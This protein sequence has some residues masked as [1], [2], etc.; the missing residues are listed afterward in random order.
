[1][2]ARHCAAIALT[3]SV[4]LAACAS[5]DFMPTTFL[6]DRCQ[7]EG[8]D[9][10]R[11]VDWSNVRVVPIIIRQDRFEPMVIRVSQNEPYIFRFTNRDDSDHVFRAP[12]FFE[13]IAVDKVV[14]AGREI[15][16][17]CMAGIGVP[18]GAVIDMHFI[19]S[20]DGRYEFTDSRFGLP[21]I[22]AAGTSGVIYIT[23]PRERVESPVNLRVVEPPPPVPLE[24][25]PETQ[26]SPFG[27][28]SGFPVDPSMQAPGLDPGMT[29]GQLPGDT[30]IRLPG[31]APIALPGDAPMTLPGDAP[32]A[33]PGDA[34]LRLPGDTPVPAA[35]PSAPS[36]GTA[37]EGLAQ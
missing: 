30:P 36:A 29:S 31:D 8:Q 33:L 14:V 6:E 4:G 13:S 16:E 1:M 34:P 28:P 3:L 11:T 27:L 24:P 12:D 21:A 37:T 18:P 15:Q 25:R 7:A 22:F 9:R 32:V 23:V 26:P 10:L 35:R 19:P 5:F 17:P 2:S 20:R